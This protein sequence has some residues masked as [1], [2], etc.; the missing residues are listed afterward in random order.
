[1]D[2]LKAFKTPDHELLIA[3]LNAYEFSK[4]TS[5]L[6]VSFLSSCQQRNKMDHYFVIRVTPGCAT[7]IISW[8]ITI[9]HV[10]KRLIVL[11]G[12]DVCNFADGTTR[13]VCN[14]SLNFVLNELEHNF[15]IAEE[16]FQKDYRKTN[17]EK[18]HLLVT[19]LKF[20]QIWAKTGSDVI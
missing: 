6:L 12:C 13:S 7:R 9:Q 20:E 1:M 11:L 8:S 17:F 5:M 18:S 2:L 14:K 3:M 15:L 4:K 16:L 10:F 19:C